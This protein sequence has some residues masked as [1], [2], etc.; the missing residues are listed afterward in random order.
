MLLKKRGIGTKFIF[1]VKP[2]YYVEERTKKIT[3]V[4]YRDT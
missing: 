1:T 4:Q 3:F 2:H